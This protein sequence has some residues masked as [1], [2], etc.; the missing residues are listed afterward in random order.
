MLSFRKKEFV[1]PQDSVEKYKNSRQLENMMQFKNSEKYYS[2]K[3]IISM[4][5]IGV[6]EKFTLQYV[7]G[8]WFFLLI[9]FPSNVVAQD[10]RIKIRTAMDTIES[11]TCLKF[12]DKDATQL[13]KDLGHSEYVHIGR[14][15]NKG[16]NAMIGYHREMGVP[17]PMNL[18]APACVAHQGTVQHELLHVVGLLHEQARA[19]RDNAVNVYWENIDKGILVYLYKV[20]KVY[21]SYRKKFL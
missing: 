10:E 5:K 14:E 17:H 3:F 16:C 4:G 11:K 6:L 20:Y 21:V 12:V 9:C 7:A 1:S 2:N 19:D 15:R 18:E 13:P 8:G